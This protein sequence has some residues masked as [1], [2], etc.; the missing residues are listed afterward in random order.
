MDERG[1]PPT[2]SPELPDGRDEGRRAR[3]RA[4]RALRRRPLSRAEL[5]ARLERAGH[6]E[7]VVAATIDD[8]ASRGYLDEAA[9]ADVVERDAERRRLGSLRVAQR[10]R[11]RGLPEDLVEASETRLR[12]GD[13]ERARALLARRFGEGASGDR[14]V[15]ARAFRLLLARGFPPDVARVALGVDVDEGDREA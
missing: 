11:R 15:R 13:L 7:A 8:L 5:R 6:G 2:S 4:L 1:R 14:A 10:L 12:Q 9:V 3:E